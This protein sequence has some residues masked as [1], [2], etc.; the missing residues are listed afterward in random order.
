MDISGINFLPS[1]KLSKISPAPR[2]CWDNQITLRCLTPGFIFLG[3]ST[4][5]M[6]TI[7]AFVISGGPASDQ[8]LPPPTEW[9][10]S[11]PRVDEPAAIALLACTGPFCNPIPKFVVIFFQKRS[12]NSIIFRPQRTWIFPK[13]HELRKI[14]ITNIRFFTN[15][16]RMIIFTL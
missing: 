6:Q 10:Q 14:I 7:T 3:Y 4:F 11:S 9:K 13:L 5:H 12:A 8:P 2:D 16:I 1:P 15:K